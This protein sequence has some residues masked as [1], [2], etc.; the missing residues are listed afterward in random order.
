[1]SPTCSFE[2]AQDAWNTPSKA[3]SNAFVICKAMLDIPFVNDME[4]RLSGC[5]YCAYFNMD[6]SNEKL[7]LR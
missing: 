3:F 4:L 7:S 5:K 6:L 1:M 2:I